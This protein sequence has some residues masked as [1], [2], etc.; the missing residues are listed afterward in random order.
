MWDR[1]TPRSEPRPGRRRSRSLA[2]AK[3][4]LR[5]TGTP[6][7]RCSA[8]RCTRSALLQR[9]KIEQPVEEAAAL[10]GPVALVPLVPGQE[11]PAPG[12]GDGDVEDPSLLVQALPA[13][14]AQGVPAREA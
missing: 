7:R 12:P 4:R 13:A 3:I 2:L 9:G 11:E 1:T 6:R 10:A 8:C 14:V 5:S